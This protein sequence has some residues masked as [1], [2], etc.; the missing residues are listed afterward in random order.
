MK[1]ALTG[2][3]NTSGGLGLYCRLGLECLQN[4]QH[5]GTDRQTP[6]LR[7]KNSP[8][9]YSILGQSITRSKAETLA[10]GTLCWLVGWTCFSNFRTLVADSEFFVRLWYAHAYMNSRP[11]LHFSS[12][13]FP[14][15]SSPGGGGNPHHSL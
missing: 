9:P 5:G 14:S 11:H 2:M 7:T 3:E 15:C 1:L 10:S 12:F 8:A 6:F 4:W 13:Y